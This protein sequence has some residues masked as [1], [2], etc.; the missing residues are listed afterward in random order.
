MK[1]EIKLNKDNNSELI[2]LYDFISEQNLKSMRFTIQQKESEI[3]TLG[4]VDYLPIIEL[5]LGSSVIAASVK[6]IFDIL[7]NYFDLKK[8][9]IAKQSELEKNKL[10]LYKIELTIETNDNKKVD[11]K[12]ASFDQN[13]R[14]EFFKS[15]D[16]IFSE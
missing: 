3:G 13:E 9:K 8:V 4:A 1:I 11:L 6:G 10:E 16:N 12:F 2:D 15:I 7:K 14:S 5:V